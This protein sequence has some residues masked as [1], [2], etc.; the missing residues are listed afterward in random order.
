M[1][2]EAIKE[3]AKRNFDDTFGKT[4]EEIELMMQNHTP[5]TLISDLESIPLSRSNFVIAGSVALTALKLLNRPTHDIDIVVS[6]SMY[7][8]ANELLEKNFKEAKSWASSSTFF[9]EDKEI[10]VSKY[11]LPSGKVLDV[12]FIDKLPSNIAMFIGKNAFKVET[13][14]SILKAKRAYLSTGDLEP[15]AITKQKEDI[16]FIKDLLG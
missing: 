3:Y 2:I 14:P 7:D 12:F 1:N 5:A 4:T 16:K 13:L 10:D 11:Y 6:S 8:D 9:F 15:E